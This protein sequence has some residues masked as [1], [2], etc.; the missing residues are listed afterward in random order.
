MQRTATQRSYGHRIEK[1]VAH[2]GERLDQPLTLEALA[3]VG[4]FSPYHF[5]RIYRGLMGET[6]ADTLRRMRLHRAAVE[7]L[8]GAQTLAAI[9]RK[10]GY[11]STAAF[12]RAFA[13]AY[14]CPPGEFR[15]RRGADAILAPRPMQDPFEDA[16]MY[17]V[18]IAQRAPVTVAALRHTGPYHDIGT[19]FERLGAWAGG[20]GIADN[21][22]FGVYYDD[23]ES[24]PAEALASDACIEIPD[25][26]ALENGG[27]QRLTIAGGRYAVLIHTGPYAE[28][29]RPYRWLYSEWLPN[30]G[31]E[32]A[33]A[34]VVEEYL[35]D[36]RALPP[37]Q[38]RTAICMP[39]REV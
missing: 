25:A 5:H 29:E 19:A 26:F 22:S 13:Q 1:V 9:A 32:A 8:H 6:V 36:P 24:K 16:H 38:W 30:S 12:N 35:N 2:L 15:R 3:A 18:D 7:L 10:C 31:E 37:S 27:P 23:P 39:L 11:G 34:P 28:L 20:R 33:D 4:H 21:R 14:G 17:Q